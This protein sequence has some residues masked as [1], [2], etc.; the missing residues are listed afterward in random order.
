MATAKLYMYERCSMCRK[1]RQWLDANGI[2]YETA[3]IRE[4]PPGEEELERALATAGGN[5]RKII[6]TSSPDYRQAGLKDQL[7]DMSREEVFARLRSQG[8]LVKRPFL[9]AGETACAG[10]DL[11]A[12]KNALL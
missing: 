11:G 1:A 7:D 3:S 12:W 10:F 2:E 5:I 4:T 9:A 8:N 6:N